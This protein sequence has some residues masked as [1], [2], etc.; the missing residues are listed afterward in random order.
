MN[1]TILTSRLWKN[2]LLTSRVGCLWISPNKCSAL[3]LPVGRT[4]RRLTVAPA[5]T[6]FSGDMVRK[7][8]ICKIPFCSIL[9][10]LLGV[11]SA[12][13]STATEAQSFSRHS[14]AQSCA[15]S[16]ACRE[17]RCVLSET[18]WRVKFALRARL[19]Q[20]QCGSVTQLRSRWA[21]GSTKSGWQR[22]STTGLTWYARGQVCF[23]IT[24]CMWGLT[25]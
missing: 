16:P 4:P 3:V 21:S 11:P 22:T 15:G 12:S 5:C 6:D 25:R 9:R 19:Q 2:G 10:V 7:R 20:C 24:P 23:G 17:W 14:E 13:C 8:H 1:T 18:W